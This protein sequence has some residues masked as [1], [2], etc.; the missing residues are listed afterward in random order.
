MTK[1][2]LVSPAE[3]V[4]ESVERGTCF[5]VVSSFQ[6]ITEDSGTALGRSLGMLIFCVQTDFDIRLV[7]G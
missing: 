1:K 7:E 5:T 4:W 2:L 3:R 6:V